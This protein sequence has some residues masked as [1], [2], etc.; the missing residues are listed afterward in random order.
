MSEILSA[1]KSW[2]GRNWIAIV[3]S[4]GI[5]SLTVFSYCI[6]NPDSL[7][8][9]DFIRIVG[10]TGS[11]LL[12]VALVSIYSQLQS[13]ESEQLNIQKQQQAILTQNESP[14]LTL[15]RWDI[16][17]NT[18]EFQLTNV[19][20]GT[21][22]R[23]QYIVIFRP[24]EGVEAPQQVSPETCHKI[25]LTRSS[26]DDSIGRHRTTLQPNHTGLFEGHVRIPINESETALASAD[27]FFDFE[28]GVNRLL[29]EFED[30]DQFSLKIGVY[31]ESELNTVAPQYLH[32]LDV[33]Y[34]RSALE[35]S[36]LSAV[37][38]HN[39]I[40]WRN[41]EQSILPDRINTRHSQY[42]SED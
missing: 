13:I 21:A 39:P 14:T 18:V 32:I 26:D 41:P 42:F 24:I 36:T 27:Q 23:I 3:L 37:V 20:Q 30:A 29:E 8:Y 16:N 2:T 31:Y 6:F 38:Q 10:V 9:T 7:T 28:G 22:L 17:D 34:P 12:T 35:E 1:V 19:G 11:L 33:D 4:F 15:D 5:V 25:Q 40:G